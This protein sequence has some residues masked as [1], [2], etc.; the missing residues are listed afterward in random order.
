MEKHHHQNKLPRNE[1]KKPCFPLFFDHPGRVG[2][3]LR[4]IL[5]RR[6][7]PKTKK[8]KNGPKNENP[9]IGKRYFS[10]DFLMAPKARV[11]KRSAGGR[12]FLK[13]RRKC[14]F[15][16]PFLGGPSSQGECTQTILYYENR[17]FGTLRGS[18]NRAKI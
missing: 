8:K 11:N 5:L 2:K 3:N 10:P 13:L 9:K 6:T 4:I 18:K 7:K 14:F 12:F 1:Q 15:V 16:T 17:G